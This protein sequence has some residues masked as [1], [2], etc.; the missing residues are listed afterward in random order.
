VAYRAGFVIGQWSK[1]NMDTGNKSLKF[2]EVRES[3]PEDLRPVYD[4]MVASYSFY[5]LKHHGRE[6]VSY[7]VIA[8]LVKDGWRPAAN[9]AG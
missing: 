8:D 4:E 7:Q 5:S 3:L 6:F 1:K 2:H 9:S